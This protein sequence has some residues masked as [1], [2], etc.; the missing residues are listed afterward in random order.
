M[1]K[2]IT[3]FL[4]LSCIFYVNATDA[5]LKHSYTFSDGAKDSPGVGVTAVDGT[6]NGGGIISNGVYS[7]TA[8]GYISLDALILQFADLF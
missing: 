3:T 1:K 4:L 6:L 8:D 2:S 5:V 7:N